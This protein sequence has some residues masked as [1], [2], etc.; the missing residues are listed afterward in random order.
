MKEVGRGLRNLFGGGN[1]KMDKLKSDLLKLVEGG[2]GFFLRMIH[3]NSRFAE[4]LH[5]YF[6]NLNRSCARIYVARS[7]KRHRITS[8]RLRCVSSLGG[9]HPRHRRRHAKKNGP[10]GVRGANL[11]HAACKPPPILK[12]PPPFPPTDGGAR[13]ARI[14][15]CHSRPAR[16][17]A[18]RRCRVGPDL[19]ADRVTP[20]C[21][22]RA[23]RR[24][25]PPRR[26]TNRPACAARPRARN[27]PHRPRRRAR[28]A[29]APL[30]RDCMRRHH[31]HGTPR[32]RR[33]RRGAHS[34]ARRAG[35]CRLHADGPLECVR[36]REPDGR[37]RLD[38]H[39]LS[40]RRCDPPGQFAAAPGH[41]RQCVDR[42]RAGGRRGVW[43][44]VSRADCRPHD[45]RDSTVGCLHALPAYR[46]QA[47]MAGAFATGARDVD[48]TVAG[49]RAGR[50]EEGA[51]MIRRVR[52]STLLF[53]GG[54]GGRKVLVGAGAMQPV[55]AL[56]LLL[57]LPRF[58]R[59][60]A[61]GLALRAADLLAILRDHR[62]YLG[63]ERAACEE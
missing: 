13:G 55:S 2:A 43:T 62:R 24:R 27:L 40:G 14:R 10:P 46:R 17:R 11:R 6:Q 44:Q 4:N 59:A 56:A 30:R 37:R 49:G 39:R 15:A 41:R 52:W 5:F 34:R 53:A 12:I 18:A 33:L 23:R 9:G 63:V 47:K 3:Q 36:E 32:S 51:G 20:R 54:T 29:V 25:S 50:H 16:P 7:R 60:V 1:D 61:A 22:S 8:F 38:R 48:A 26:T 35:G 19:L 42:G 31:R 58:V 21:P 45:R 57:L 28:D